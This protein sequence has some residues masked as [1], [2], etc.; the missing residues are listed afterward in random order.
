MF[1]GRAIRLPIRRVR[2]GKF[3][4]AGG[5]SDQLIGHKTPQKTDPTRPKSPKIWGEGLLGSRNRVGLALQSYSETKIA[6]KERTSETK[7]SLSYLDHQIAR[8]DDR[9]VPRPRS[10]SLKSVSASDK[11]L[12][13]R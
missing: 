11:S 12:L 1:S 7:L 8:S 4:G 9:H 13:S 10:I 3:G 2:C 6:F 5:E